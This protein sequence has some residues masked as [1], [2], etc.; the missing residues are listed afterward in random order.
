MTPTTFMHVCKRDESFFNRWLQYVRG[1]GDFPDMV[2]WAEPDV[3]VDHKIDRVFASTYGYPEITT[4]VWH[5]AVTSVGG[6][7]LYLETDAWPCA[8]NWYDVI[9]REYERLGSPGA[10]VTSSAHPPHDLVGGLAV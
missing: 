9:C 5:E 1:L 4:H 3:R 7:V 10:L 8:P 2:V 6:P